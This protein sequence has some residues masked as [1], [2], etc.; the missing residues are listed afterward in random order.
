[1]RC[2]LREFILKGFPTPLISS[3]LGLKHHRTR[4]VKLAFFPGEG[5][6]EIPCAVLLFS[7]LDSFHVPGI[8]KDIF[9]HYPQCKGYWV[10]Q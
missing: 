2:S 1:M 4:G 6:T 8:S 10:S 9:N 3:W 5:Q 7:R